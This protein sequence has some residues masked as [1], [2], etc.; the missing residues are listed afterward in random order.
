MDTNFENTL[1]QS[2]YRLDPATGV[3]SR[4][5]FQGINYSD[6]DEF[7]NRIEDTINRATDLTVFS[8][9]LKL[10][11]IDWPSTYHLSPSRANILR[12]FQLSNNQDILEIG[13]GCG[14]LSRYLGECGANVLALEGSQRRA[15]IARSRT[16][17][18][19]NVTVASA[20]LSSFKT[21]CQF[22]VVTLIG[23]LEYAAMDSTADDPAKAMLAN[24]ASLV[25]PDGILILAIENQLGL[26]YFAGAPEDHIQIP[27]Y[28]L[29][30]R[31][32]KEQPR[33]YGRETLS[34]MLS[35]SGF[36]DVKFFAPFPDYKL[37]VS[38]LTEAATEHDSF[39]VSA[40]ISQ[41]V[42]HDPQSPDVVA[43]SPELVWPQIFRNKLAL[44]LSNS[45]LVMASPSMG[46][47]VDPSILAYH[48]STNRIPQYVKETVFVTQSNKTISVNCQKLY[49]RAG[50]EHSTNTVKHSLVE[51]SP[52]INGHLLSLEFT[53]I[54][55]RDGWLVDEVGAFYDRYLGLLYEILMKAEPSL[56]I[57]WVK[58]K[59]RRLD[60]KLPGKFFDISPQ[61]IVIDEN[62][63]GIV[64]DQEWELTNEVELGFCLFR[65]ALLMMGAVSRFGT[66][67][68]NIRYSR[69]EFIQDT[70]RAANF[71][72]DDAQIDDYREQEALIQ[73][74]ITGKPVENFLDWSADH[75]MQTKN[76]TSVLVDR[77][78]TIEHL[79]W[80]LTEREKEID[81]VYQSNSWNVTAPMRRVVTASRNLQEV[82]LTIHQRSMALGGYFSAG[83]HIIKIVAEEGVS[84]INNRWLEY[85]G[86]RDMFGRDAGVDYSRWKT[87]YANTSDNFRSKVRTRISAFKLYPLISIIMPVYD[88][89]P[90][91]L[92]EAINSVRHQLY[93]HWELCIADDCSTDSRIRPILE[94]LSQADSRI[95]VT[96]RDLNGHISAASNTALESAQGSWIALLDHDDQLSEDALFWVADV[97]NHNPTV[98]LIY[99]D[100][101]KLDN[102]GVRQ[103][104]YFKPD[105]NLDL[106]RSQNLFCHLGVYQKDLLSSVGGFRVGLE[107]AQDYDLALRCVEKVGSNTIWHI[108]RVLYHW[109]AHDA[110]TASSIDNKPYARQASLRALAEHFQ[111]LQIDVEVT[112]VQHGF[113]TKYSLPTDLPL[114][115]LIIPVRNNFKL[116]QQCIESIQEKT[117]YKNY[118]IL[119][120]DNGS[121]N[122]DI[123]D[124]LKQLSLQST[125]TVIRDDRPFNFSALNN[126]AVNNANGEIVG[127]INNDTEVITPEWLTEM[128]SHAIRPGVGAVGA[129]LRYSDGSLQHGGVILGLGGVA[130]HSHK[131]LPEKLFHGKQSSKS[132]MVRRSPGYFGRAAL[133]SNFSAVTAACLVIKKSIYQKVGGLDELHLGIAFN[134]VDLCC[135]LLEAGHANVWTPYAELFHHESRTR[136]YE[137]T[138]TKRRRFKKEAEY[139]KSKWKELLA[140]DPAYSPNLTLNQED[141]SYAWPPRIEFID[142]S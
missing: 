97:I 125:I 22:D 26:K 89:E 41:S 115:T 118:E 30:G 127:L 137:N 69:R 122:S 10:H 106:F 83:N 8:A 140:F 27:M 38:I 79:D 54:V 28:G 12:P 17:D 141:F 68:D 88:P 129:K 42:K 90:A 95:K 21:T 60:S 109:R 84:G 94:E 87:L 101:D 44:E 76:L 130:G 34:D 124:Y 39:D 135:R 104:P 37:P 126:R 105:W 77:D 134:D 112:S 64:I 1:D 15:R 65:S 63:S 51:K 117:T 142:E 70:F 55:I 20:S 138:K 35:L 103:N 18:Q 71:I 132:K 72:I 29:E 96:F 48:Y 50:I 119:I 59:S 120:I 111:R 61:N 5:G 74:Q 123:V 16:R 139:M 7:E 49:P 47:I 25:K 102:N 45:F 99:S 131:N 52:Y 113:R 13:A 73:T 24:I 31:Y 66:N 86:H 46:H 11:C 116:T 128:V 67:G 108:P 78:A 93:E 33:T 32:Q 133:V 58:N 136:G 98:Q 2:G 110:S 80:L 53:Q 81:L 85:R 121:D 40:L 56:S 107:G 92:I 36:S 43:F 9:E 57:S 62:G 75:V 6:G 4:P 114:V 82:L 19:S 3:W 100:E 14:A 91:W 23:V